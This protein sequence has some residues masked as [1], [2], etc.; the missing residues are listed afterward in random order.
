MLW[1]AVP[2]RGPGT[3]FVSSLRRRA[4]RQQ[5]TAAGPLGVK[6]LV[7][8]SNP[9]EVSIYLWGTYEPEV[10][11]A[12]QRVLPRGRTAIDI[13]ANCGVLSVM[14]SRMVGPHGR[15]VAIDP[16]QAACERIQQQVRLN[17][18]ENVDIHGV[19]LGQVPDHE[20]FRMGRVG[21]GLLPQVD[22]EFT[23]G[24]P[25]DVQVL[26]VDEI[27]A[28]LDGPPVGLIKIDTD[29]SEIPIL[30]GAE[31]ILRRHRPALVIETY[32]E[33][34]RRRGL[35]PAALAAILDEHGYE[36]FVPQI[37]KPWPWRATPPRVGCFAPTPLSD[38]ADG[39]VDE[40]NVIAINRGEDGAQARAALLAS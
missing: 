15:V 4:R 19:A 3:L 26:T 1:R 31:G 38:L 7:D 16:S 11:A 6:Y 14:M 34:F 30:H 33:G 28:K 20:S 23:T 2:V 39:R 18:M 25:I 5:V 10:V 35:S 12:M 29:G 27:V 17:A 13:G 37:D 40:V 8:P 36:L 21:I 24:P 22:A 32:L 9:P